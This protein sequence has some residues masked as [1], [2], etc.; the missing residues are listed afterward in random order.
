M[1]K[2]NPETVSGGKN[3]LYAQA[4]EGGYQLVNSTPEI[5]YVLKSTSA[6]DVF[7]VN[8]DGKNGVVYKNE[9]KWF[10]EMDEKRSKAKELN[11]KF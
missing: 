2:T 5:V 6:P 7:I 9:G 1:V 10:I 4:I 11:I 8:K 3:V